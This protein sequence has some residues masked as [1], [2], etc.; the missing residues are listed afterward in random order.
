[1]SLNWHIIFVFVVCMVL[2]LQTSAHAD[3][4]GK[5]NRFCIF[6]HMSLLLDLSEGES[7]DNKFVERSDSVASRGFGCGGPTNKN[8]Y[9]CN[10]HCKSNGFKGGYCNAA[11]LW[12]R[13]DCYK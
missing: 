7:D 8:E 9:Q 5:H 2:V 10:R 3:R 12:F 1:M 6:F 13:C 11:L 4:T